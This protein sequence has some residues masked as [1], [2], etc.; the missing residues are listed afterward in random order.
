MKKKN[1]F[2]S[3]KY[4]EFQIAFILK[5]IL[6]L[7]Y[8]IVIS[9]LFFSYYN[10]NFLVLQIYLITSSFFISFLTFLKIHSVKN[11]KDFLNNNHLNILFIKIKGIGILT[12]NTLLLTVFA[13]LIKQEVIFNIINNFLNKYQLSLTMLEDL[14]LTLYLIILF[15]CLILINLTLF[16]IKY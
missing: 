9:I 6:K 8:F 3:I 10:C 15:I 5:N 1:F 4:K 7:C 12:L 13:T 14:Q 16:F 2:N 11:N